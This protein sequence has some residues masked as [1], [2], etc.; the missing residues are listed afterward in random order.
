M[1]GGDAYGAA[2]P[3]DIFEQFFGGQGTACYAWCHCLLIIRILP[4]CLPSC[5]QG[6]VDISVQF[7]DGQAQPVMHVAIAILSS[8]CYALSSTCYALSS[9]CLLLVQAEDINMLQAH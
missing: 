9:T 8:T 7:F 5:G 2:S 3:F 6:P 1:S 4:F